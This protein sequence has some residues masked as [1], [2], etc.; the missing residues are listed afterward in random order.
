[1]NVG[2]LKKFLEKYDVPDATE[3]RDSDG[4]KLQNLSLSVDYDFAE[5]DPAHI[6]LVIDN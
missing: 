6:D 5:A 4:T 1:M 2:D 3:I